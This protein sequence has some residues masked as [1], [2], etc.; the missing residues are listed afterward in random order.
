MGGDLD[1]EAALVVGEVDAAGQVQHRLRRQQPQVCQTAPRPAPNQ[2]GAPNHAR[3]VARRDHNAPW[4]A[5]GM[6]RRFPGADGAPRLR[7]KALRV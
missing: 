3:G 2:R 7:R 1:D 6:Q 5:D 4:R